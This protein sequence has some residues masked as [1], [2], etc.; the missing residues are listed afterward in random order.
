MPYPGLAVIQLTVG[1]AAIGH[2]KTRMPPLMVISHSQDDNI[3]ERFLREP[4]G[5]PEYCWQVAWADC[6]ISSRSIK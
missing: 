3:F 5:T 6:R 1:V 2:G 4:V